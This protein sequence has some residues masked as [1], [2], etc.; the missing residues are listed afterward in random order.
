[1]KKPSSAAYADALEAASGMALDEL[2]ALLGKLD[3]DKPVECKRVLLAAVPALVDKYGA[4]AASAAA[5]YYVSE[6]GAV[7][8][9]GYEPLLAPP[10]DRGAVKAKVRYSLRYLFEE[11][12]DDERGEQEGVS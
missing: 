12:E 5:E 11:V 7:L 10:I 6:R 4:M 2:D 1:M 9:G 8:G 3:L